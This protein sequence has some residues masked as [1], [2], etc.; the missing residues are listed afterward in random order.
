MA[1]DAVLS[2]RKQ[3]FESFRGCFSLFVFDVNCGSRLFS[4]ALEN[5][6]YEIT[7]AGLVHLKG[8]TNLQELGISETGIT[9]VEIA[10]LKRFTKL[11][12]LTIGAHQFTSVG[13]SRLK[14]LPQ[15]RSLRLSYMRDGGLSLLK[16]MDKLE[17]LNFFASPELSDAGLVHLKELTKLK[18]LDLQ[19]TDVNGAGVADLQKALPDCEIKHSP[20]SSIICY[21]TALLSVGQRLTSS[22]R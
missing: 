19:S 17:T 2:E 11:Q 14:D 15:L 3:R 1:Q 18:R 6:E 12:S 13:V 7:D 5:G 9:D 16:H 22:E 8:L 10:Y 4:A 20:T 21:W